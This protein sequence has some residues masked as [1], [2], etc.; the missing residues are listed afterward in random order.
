VR[1][2]KAK[3]KSGSEQLEASQSAEPVIPMDNRILAERA[4]TKSQCEISNHNKDKIQTKIRRRK[5]AA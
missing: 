1:S 3:H 2:V 5:N 4:S